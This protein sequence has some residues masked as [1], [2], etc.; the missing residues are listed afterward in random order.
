MTEIK[1]VH[2]GKDYRLKVILD[3]G[4]VIM[5]NLKPKLHTMRFGLLK[6]PDFFMR[7]RT[8]G[9]MIFWDGKVELSISEV[10]EILGK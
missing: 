4:S 3:N 10:F 8:D 2:P 6:D 9:S 7:A 5:L 1:E